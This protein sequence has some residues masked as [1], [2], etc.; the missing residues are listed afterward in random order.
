MIPET[1]GSLLHQCSKTGAF[2]YG[3]SLHA[4]VIKTGMQ[5]D[6]IVS[7]HLL[8]VYAKCGNL[9][10][11]RQIFN[12]MSERNLVTWSAMISGYDQGGK[13]LLAV[14]LLSQMQVE[15]NEYIF[16]SAI[17]A[18][19]SLLASRLGEQ[20]HAWAVKLG[21]S[22]NSFVS[23]SL[24]SMYMKC[25]QSREALTTFSSTAEPNSV[26]YNA[27]IMGLVENQQHE[28]GFEVFRLMCQQGLIPDRFTFVGVLGVCTTADQL[29]RG[30]ELHCQ[31]NKLKLDYTAFIGNLVIT[32]YSKFRLIEEAEKVFKYIEEKDVISWNTYI[33]ACSHFADYARGLTVFR[34]MTKEISVRPDDFTYT[35][36]LA[37]CAGL[38][39]IPH[40][41]QIHS[42]LIRTRLDKDV[43]VCNALVNMYAKC[44]CIEYAYTVFSQMGF[45][46]LVSWNSIIAGYASHGLARKAV[47]IF[48]QMKERGINPDSVTFIGLLSACNHAGLVDKGQEY[49]NSMVD[50]YAIA[51]D[52]EHFSCLIDL[53]GRA[54]R[55]KE[56]EEYIE[57]FPSGH[58]PI[59]LGCLLSACRLHGDVVLGERLARRLLKVQPI[60]TSPYVLLSNLYASDRKWDGVADARK[61]LKGSGLK[62]EPGHSLIEVKGIVE[63]FTVGN[64][65]HSRI[66]E[67]VDVLE[68]LTWEN[69]QISLC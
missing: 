42:H 7:N 26:S 27:L 57:K 12:D 8:N 20:I 16:A 21:Y 2:R 61:M 36:V 23:N 55:L 13:P 48:E 62:K 67:I 49:F 10:F 43:T 51:P 44:G 11:A 33:A 63:K 64:F 50:I 69:E 59:I 28:R 52:V 66:E 24:V 60:T 15:P 6:V 5:C 37:V 30:M 40:G 68:N 9:N 32:M 31:I 14:E 47:E 35:S 41:K 46:N 38:A 25:G 56:A 17:S 1:L 22:S 39:S 53:L 29:C 19:A 3:L 54:G 18:C 58:D 34:K 65:S 4:A 45:R